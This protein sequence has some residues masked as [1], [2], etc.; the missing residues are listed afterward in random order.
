MDLERLSRT[1]KTR[2]VEFAREEM[3]NLGIKKIINSVGTIDSQEGHWSFNISGIYR[4]GNYL[5]VDKSI[6]AMSGK[7][8]LITI[9]VILFYDYVSMILFMLSNESIYKG[10]D[11]YTLLMN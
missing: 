8:P 4:G 10:G 3:N 6:R 1:I 7:E 9:S 2:G 5:L 11:E